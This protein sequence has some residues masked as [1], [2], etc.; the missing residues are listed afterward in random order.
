MTSATDA[1]AAMDRMYR[2]QRHIYDLTRKFY[3]F[4]R[5]TLIE[6]LPVGPGETLCEVGC[7]TARNLVMLAKRHPRARFFGVDAS[8]EMLKSARENLVNGG[9]AGQVPLA[10]SLAQDFDWRATFALDR[11]FDRLLYSYSLSMMDDWQAALEHGFKQLRSGGSVHIVDF[12]D[13]A[14]LPAWFKRL[15][16]AWLDKFHVRFRPEIRRYF[17]ALEKSGRGRMTYRDHMRGYAYLLT[18]ETGR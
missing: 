1:R 16:G 4:G 2:V 12:G 6:R 7:G 8:E 10:V 18:F 5:D 11:P 9:V 17:E 3:L 14:G 13:Q 15:L